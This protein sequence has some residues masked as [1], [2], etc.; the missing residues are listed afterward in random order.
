MRVGDTTE[1][2]YYIT[3]VLRQSMTNFFKVEVFI[4]LISFTNKKSSIVT[5]QLLKLVKKFPYSN[6]N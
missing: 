6:L 1:T 3:V 2:I 4:R 5:S